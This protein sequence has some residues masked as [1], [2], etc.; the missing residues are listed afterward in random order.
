VECEAGS[1]DGERDPS[2]VQVFFR[3]RAGIH[4]YRAVFLDAWHNVLRS[5][6]KLRMWEAVSDVQRHVEYVTVFM[7]LSST[8]VPPVQTA[9]S[10]TDG[11][12]GPCESSPTEP[13]EELRLCQLRP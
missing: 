2:R 6:R 7:K 4:K 8:A 13:D 10:S 5:G 3:L 9:P 12:T 1:Q 11:Q